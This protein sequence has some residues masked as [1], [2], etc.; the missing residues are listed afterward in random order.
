MKANK[1]VLTLA[2]DAGEWSASSPAQ[3]PPW[4]YPVPI[5]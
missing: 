2:L 1:G 4:I 5:G 3:L